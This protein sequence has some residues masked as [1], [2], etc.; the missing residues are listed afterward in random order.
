MDFGPVLPRH[1]QSTLLFEVGLEHCTLSVNEPDSLFFGQFA[2]FSVQC[3]A[4]GISSALFEVKV[5]QQYRDAD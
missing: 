5:P 4:R 2:L 1:P 3:V